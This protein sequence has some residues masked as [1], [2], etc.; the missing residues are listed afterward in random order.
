MLRVT[1][2]FLLVLTAPAT[3]QVTS[4][5]GP[6]APMLKRNVTV[7]SDIVR[8]GD[9]IENAGTAAQIPIFRAPDL[10]ATGSVSAEHVLKAARAHNVL[11][12]DAGG[13]SNVTVTHT[14]RVIAGKEIEGAIAQA[15]AARHGPSETGE[16]VVR[17]DRDVSAMHVEPTATAALRVARL[18]YEPRSGRFDIQFELPGSPLARRLPLHFGGTAVEMVETAVLT[19][20]LAR[21][22]IIRN[23]DVVMEKRPK[24]QVGRDFIGATEQAAGLS[25]RRTIQAGQMLRQSDLTKP[26]LVQRNEMVTLIFEMPGMVLTSRGK[27]LESGT[28][29]DVIAVVNVQSKRTVQ[30]TVIGPGIVMVTPMSPRLAANTISPPAASNAA[31]HPTRT[32]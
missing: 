28:K 17:L 24:A 1:L 10:G 4:A 27:T 20:P 13:I 29:S 21:G 32:E 30:A 14:S 9:L 7:A 12:V 26:V 31:R 11:G 8:I 15:V 22:D 18:S 19:R 3:A 5:L 23:S 6:A 2:A 25:L 16:L